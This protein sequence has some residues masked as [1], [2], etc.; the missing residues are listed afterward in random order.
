MS[1]VKKVAIILGVLALIAALVMPIAS[2]AARGATTAP[3]NMVLSPMAVEFNN[4][5]AEVVIMGSGFE[6]EQEVRLLLTDVNGVTSDI[7]EDIEANDNGNWAVVWT[8]ERYSRKE[9]ASEDIYSII[10]ADSKYT[11]LASAPFGFYNAKNPREEWPNWAQAL[12]P[13]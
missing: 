11:A 6:P 5:K 3:A 4:S 2:A 13:E 10:A 9:V 7:G 12:V 1:K 8:V